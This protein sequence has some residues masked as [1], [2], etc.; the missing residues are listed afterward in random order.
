LNAILGFAQLLEMDALPLEQ[1]DNVGQI[2]RAGRH[3]LALINEVLDVSRIEAGRLQLSLEP[4]PVHETLQLAIALVQPSSAEAGIALRADVVDERLHVLADRQ[5]LHQVLLNLLSNAMK[6]NRPDGV[7]TVSCERVA[8][9]RL[10]IHVS[11][12]GRG[13]AAENLERLFTP[14]DRL[15]AEASGVEGTGLGLALSKHLVD[16]MGGTVH[17]HSEVGVGSTFSVE[18]PVVAGPV[19]ADDASAEVAPGHD[20]DGLSLKILYIEDNLSNLRLVERVLGRRPGVTLL[21]AMQGRVGLDLARD[22]RPDLV[23]LDRH[24]PDVSGDEVLHLLR[25]DP[26]TQDI[27]VVILS[28]DAIPGQAQRLLDAGARAYLT[29]PLDVPRLLAVVD[30]SV[31][32]PGG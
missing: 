9:N 14:F 10:R 16:A 28:A 4:V 25:A 31:H 2:L 30:E 21:S 27:P 12:T 23:L 1:K 5:R 18:L 7:V 19:A 13:I 15:G 3:L 8:L 22:H 17:V 26:R 6:Y 32:R 11:D 29:K 24:L 20:G